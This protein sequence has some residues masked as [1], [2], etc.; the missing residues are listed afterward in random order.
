MERGEKY[1]ARKL[2]KETYVLESTL[3]SRT[4]TQIEWKQI[5]HEVLTDEEYVALVIKYLFSY[6]EPRHF[7]QVKDV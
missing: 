7:K 5:E 4:L 3:T 2:Q 6:R 1:R